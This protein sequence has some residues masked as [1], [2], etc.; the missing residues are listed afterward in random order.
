RSMAHLALVWSTNGW[1]LY[2]NTLKRVEHDL[3]SSQANVYSLTSHTA[4][5]DVYLFTG[6]PADI[7]NQ[8][9]AQTGR[10]GQPE[11]WPMGVWL[12]QVEAAPAQH[13][14]SLARHLREG[15]MAFDVI[16]LA[17]P[18]V[19]GFQADKPNFEWD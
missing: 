18:A 13:M 3:G 8:Y 16:R 10:A 15:G 19:Y 2:V 1:G 4:V 12:D 14:L 11:L 5:L 6:E 9:T 7:L 17:N